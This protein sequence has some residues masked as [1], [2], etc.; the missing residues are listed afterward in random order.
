MYQHESTV[1]ADEVG[2]K[3]SEL[4]TK[5]EYER[6][7]LKEMK[8]KEDVMEK[9]FA[10]KEKEYDEIGEEMSRTKKDFAACERKDIKYRED[11]KHEV[12]QKKKAKTTSKKLT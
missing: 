5:L 10:A 6:K 11:I 4:E 1:N 12:A 7:K 2:A 8:E 9:T 3:K